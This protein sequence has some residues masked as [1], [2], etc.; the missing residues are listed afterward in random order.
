MC[1]RVSWQEKKI[2]Q[3]LHFLKKKEKKT[4]APLYNVGANHVKYS[5]FLL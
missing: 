1:H 3:P 4:I 5:W 2:R